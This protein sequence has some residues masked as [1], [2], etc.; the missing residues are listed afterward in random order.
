VRKLAIKYKDPRKLKPRLKNPRTHTPRQIKQIAASISSAG[1]YDEDVSNTRQADE[2]LAP[3]ECPAGGL[4][5]GSRANSRW[6]RAAPP[7]SVAAIALPRSRPEASAGRRR[8]FCASLPAVRIA[9][10]LIEYASRVHTVDAQALPSVSRQAAN[11]ARSASTPPQRAGAASPAT[12][13]SP[14]LRKS[15]S[16]SYPARSTSLACGA[17]SRA[18]KRWRLLSISFILKTSF[19]GDRVYR[20]V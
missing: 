4:M 7:A 11:N 14:I 10:A 5:A 3:F 9:R 12:P 20:L 13:C 19:S 1:H 6:V 16:G 18:T 15:S 2:F 17:I 8:P